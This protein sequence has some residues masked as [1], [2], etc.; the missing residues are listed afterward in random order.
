MKFRQ[1]WEGFIVCEDYMDWIQVKNDKMTKRW[2]YSAYNVRILNM[3]IKKSWLNIIL[4]NVDDRP[5]EGR[6]SQH[7]QCQSIKK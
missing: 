7:L 2:N 6:A 3:F 4:K 5:V 1:K